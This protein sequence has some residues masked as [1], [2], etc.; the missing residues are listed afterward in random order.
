[1]GTSKKK[2]KK[3]N[4]SNNSSFTVDDSGQMH[5][6]ANESEARQSYNSNRDQLRKDQ[7]ELKGVQDQIAASKE[8]KEN[9]DKW[10]REFEEKGDTDRANHFKEQS[11][12]T[13]ERTESLKAQEKQAQEKVK[14]QQ[15]KTDFAGAGIRMDGSYNPEGQQI[16]LDAEKARKEEIEENDKF[17]ELRKDTIDKNNRK[18]ELERQKEDLWHK[19]CEASS[20]GD[21][22]KADEYFEQYKQTD[23]K[24]KDATAD[25]KEAAAKSN[26]QKE[27]VKQK[28]EA[29]K[30]AERKE[31][32]SRRTPK[33]EEEKKEEE[34]HE[35]PSASKQN[36]KARPN[37]VIYYV[38]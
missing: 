31:R 21:Q 16:Y 3:N 17:L 38:D 18:C 8:N 27:V 30:D 29:R 12:K 5:F 1:M 14:K 11:K 9:Y 25:Y 2:K 6:A 35:H 7:A 24:L 20:A 28:T 36:K 37:D 19:H 26:A 23:E 34:R 15:K 32:D 13:A 4:T 22:E 33:K 10:A